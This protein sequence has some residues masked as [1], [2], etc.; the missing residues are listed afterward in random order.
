MR[1]KQV[2]RNVLSFD[3]WQK[4]F[5]KSGLKIRQAV[6]YMDKKASCLL[7]LLQYLSVYS[8]ISYKIF[9]KWVLFPNFFELVPLQKMFATI[10]AKD[11]PANSSSALFFE[12][13]NH[14]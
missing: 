4:H 2:H 5:E 9:G 13:E 10:I 14:K 12:L 6:G 3:Q 7:D 1:K 8:L 11:I